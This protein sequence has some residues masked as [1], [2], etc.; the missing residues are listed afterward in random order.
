MRAHYSLRDASFFMAFFTML[1]VALMIVIVRVVRRCVVPRMA[2]SALGVTVGKNASLHNIFFVTEAE[3]EEKKAAAHE[4][5]HDD[6]GAEH[7]TVHREASHSAMQITTV[8]NER[9]TAEAVVSIFADDEAAHGGGHGPQVSV[10]C[11]PLHF[12]RIMLTI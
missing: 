7:G 1:G 5:G 4:D 8:H 11:L 12:T 2:A 6:A 10:F 3:V 9:F